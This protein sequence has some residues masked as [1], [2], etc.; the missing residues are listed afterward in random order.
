MWLSNVPLIAIASAL[1]S[2]IVTVVW[3]VIGWRAMRAHEELTA[4]TV[5]IREELRKLAAALPPPRP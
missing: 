1:F 3:L 4:Q 5:H 2:L